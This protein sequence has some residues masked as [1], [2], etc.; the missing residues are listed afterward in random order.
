[1]DRASYRH[2]IQLNRILSWSLVA[3]SILVMVMGYSLTLLGFDGPEVLL[4]HQVVGVIFTTLFISHFLLSVS[5]IRFDW[6]RVYRSVLNGKAGRVVLLRLFQRASGWALVATA[7][8]VLLS[9]LDWFKLG[10]GRFIPFS[11]HVSFDAFFIAAFVVHVAAGLRLALLRRGNR[12]AVG[13]VSVA[14]REAIALIGGM[15]LSLIAALYL[16]RIP[17]VR[18]VADGIKGIL[19]PGQYEVSSLRPLTYGKVPSIDEKSWNLKV[20]G[21]VREPVTLN[22]DE[23]R[24]LPRTIS[25]SD[26]HCVTGW[27][28]FGNRWEGVGFREIMRMVR[29]KV[30]AKHVLF[31]C[32]VTYP[33]PPKDELFGSVSGPYTTSLPLEDLDRED[34]LLAYSLDDHDLPREHGGPLRLVVPHKYGYKSAKWVREVRFI[35]EG[36]LGFWESRGYSDTA[37]PFTNDRYSGSS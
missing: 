1:M 35:E 22:Y 9:G 6:R 21:L 11:Q 10:T 24:A 8:L 7:F 20:D 37:D 3:V 17:R 5:L 27:T 32:E 26:F 14:R 16:D 33:L 28:K 23:V 12:A 34:V 25:V 18:V 13:T 4:A 15:L 30:N 19:P 29:P 31:I 2:Q 36:E